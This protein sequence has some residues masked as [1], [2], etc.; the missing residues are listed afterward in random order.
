MYSLHYQP[1]RISKARKSLL[2]LDPCLDYSS[3][4]K[5]E[6][7]ALSPKKKTTVIYVVALVK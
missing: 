1:P 5:M 3:S 4:L 7:A 6:V 2:L